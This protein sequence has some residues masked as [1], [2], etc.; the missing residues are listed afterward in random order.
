MFYHKIKTL[1]DDILSKRSKLFAVTNYIFL[2]I[3]LGILIGICFLFINGIDYNEALYHA[4]SFALGVIFEIFLFLHVFFVNPYDNALSNEL[5]LRTNPDFVSGKRF[6]KLKTLSKIDIELKLRRSFTILLISIILYIGC[7][8][9]S[10]WAWFFSKDSFQYYD[11]VFV[12]SLISFAITL[13]LIFIIS[14]YSL[15]YFLAV[16]RGKK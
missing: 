14:Y 5:N 9:F 7:L 4:S 3:Y 8:G 1:P 11:V 15:P 12:L 6:D 13:V 10:I 2:L 16:R